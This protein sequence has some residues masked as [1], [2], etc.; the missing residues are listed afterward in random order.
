MAENWTIP[1]GTVA[2][3]TL[4]RR[5]DPSNVKD[6][7][8]CFYDGFSKR[9]VSPSEGALLHEDPWVISAR[10]LPVIDP[11]DD[12]Q[13]GR[14]RSEIFEHTGIGHREFDRVQAALRQYVRR[15][16]R[17]A[18]T[19]QAQ[20]RRGPFVPAN[21]ATIM[22]SLGTH[23]V[24]LI[25]PE[26]EVQVRLLADAFTA[27]HHVREQNQIASEHAIRSMQTA[28]RQFIQSP[29][30]TPVVTAKTNFYT[31]QESPMPDLQRPDPG[32]WVQV[33]GQV[34]K[35]QSATHPEDVLVDLESHNEQYNAYVRLDRLRLA[36][37]GPPPFAERCTHM[38]Q[39]MADGPMWRCVKYTRHPDEHSNGG[40]VR[41]ASKKT[42]GY[43]EET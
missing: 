26:D 43:F 37:E 19:G 17:H 4:H 42:V 14:L 2:R 38:V 32:T 27:A 9:W 15:Y 10:A 6:Y 29:V 40:D 8:V 30:P 18:P 13:V 41:W 7:G 24:A 16:L 36:D 21:K 39:P 22:D 11:E 5:D 20:V 1:P 25:D 3:V 28:L 12:E 35:N 34:N 23:E 33:W 31:N